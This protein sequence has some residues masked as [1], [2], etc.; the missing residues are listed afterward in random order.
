MKVPQIFLYFFIAPLDKVGNGSQAPPSSPTYLTH[1]TL[2]KCM[3]N[4]VDDI[5]TLSSIFAR[6]MTF[7][8]HE[9]SEEDLEGSSPLSLVVGESEG[10]TLATPPL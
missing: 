1:G 5:L 9:L 6:L 8:S 3:F 4:L 10:T 7:T 2:M